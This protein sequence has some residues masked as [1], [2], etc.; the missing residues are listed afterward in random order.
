MEPHHALLYKLDM[1]VP[2]HFALKI[3][4]SPTSQKS[5]PNFSRWKKGPTCPPQKPSACKVLHRPR[6]HLI[7]L[8]EGRARG[9]Q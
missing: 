1:S 3:A 9:Y 8:P 7:D 4:W 2:V 5:K 6:L